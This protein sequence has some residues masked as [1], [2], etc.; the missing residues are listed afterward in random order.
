VV[1]TAESFGLPM[2]GAEL[3]PRLAAGWEAASMKE[4]VRAIS[5]FARGGETAPLTLTY[6]DR[7]QN[8]EGSIVYE[9]EL[10]KLERKKPN[11]IDDATAFMVHSMMRGGMERGSAAGLGEMLIEK[12]FTGAGKTGTTHDFSDNWFLGYNGRV[13]CGVWLGFLQPNKT[14]YEGAFS[15]DLAM[16]VWADAMNA[17]TK[18]FGGKV[19]AQPDSV[20]E[21]KICSVSG[22]RATPYCYETVIEPSTGRPR[23]RSA[24]INEFFRK[25]SATLPFCPIHS[26]ADAVPQAGAWIPPQAINT[27]PV[28]AKDQVLLGDDPYFTEQLLADGVDRQPTR[29]SNNVLD[30]FD[31]GDGEKPLHL[32][33]PKRVKIQPE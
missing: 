28:R 24:E 33:W 27:T 23:T 20:Q 14:I 1:S 12:P 11:P 5:A 25:N 17:S 18:D 3:L 30:S 19:I 22:Q 4:A 15:R 2:K 16:P 21:V 26:G 13:S 32:P 6:V 8:A 7:V 29:K 9:R 10:G 31:L